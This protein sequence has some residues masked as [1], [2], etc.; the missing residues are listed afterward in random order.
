MVRYVAV[1]FGVGAVVGFGVVVVGRG[2]DVVLVGA[3]DDV[4]VGTAE[5]VEVG[6]VVVGAVVVV[7]PP[8]SSDAA[9][10]PVKVSSKI[11]QAATILLLCGADC[12]A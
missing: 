10:A 9:H 7:G 4:V 3:V 8:C 2:D 1:G 11:A 6:A 12:S 5:D